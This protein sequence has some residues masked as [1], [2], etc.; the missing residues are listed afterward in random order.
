[1]SPSELAYQEATEAI[2]VREI[3]DGWVISVLRMVYSDRVCIG[4][5]EDTSTYDDG[6]CY[7][8]RAMAL[9][10]AQA[11][12]RGGRPSR[13]L[14]KTGLYGALSCEWRSESGIE[15]MAGAMSSEPNFIAVWRYE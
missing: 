4:R 12:E 10:S 1:M 11:L 3:D 9:R 7:P 13:R 5:I 14:D 8:N 2:Y 15:G 6:W